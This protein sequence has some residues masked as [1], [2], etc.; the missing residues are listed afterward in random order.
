MKILRF[1]NILSFS[2]LFLFLLIACSKEQEKVVSV[3]AKHGGLKGILKGETGAKI[4]LCKINEE[5]GGDC[6][7]LSQLTD[8]TNRSSHF[9]ISMIPPGN[10]V[11]CYTTS[12]EA[13]K[14][15]F[16]N[17]DKL[18]FS[19]G[20]LNIEAKMQG[21]KW[22]TDND[23]SSDTCTVKKGAELGFSV[24]TGEARL[25][26]ASIKHN[27]SGLIMEFRDG[28]FIN[29]QIEANKII[30]ENIIPWGK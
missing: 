24:A 11:L 15:N 6:S 19:L 8:I 4:V 9:A 20:T 23:L 12:K 25:L 5:N 29:T 28:G 10:Y 13:S 1:F 2:I 22:I 21:G 30:E 17:D 3:D 7:I 27:A 26:N 16:K 14:L 18:T